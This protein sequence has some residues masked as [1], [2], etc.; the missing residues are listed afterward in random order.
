[1]RIRRYMSGQVGCDISN[2]FTSDTSNYEI[3]VAYIIETKQQNIIKTAVEKKFP[4]LPSIQNFAIYSE[5]S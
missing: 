2:V 5:T 4:E 3:S 1:M